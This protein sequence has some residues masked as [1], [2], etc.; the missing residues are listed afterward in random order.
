VRQIKYWKIHIFAR[1]PE[2]K[3][4]AAFALDEVA[5]IT[6]LMFFFIYLFAVGMALPSIPVHSQTIG[7]KQQYGNGIVDSAGQFS[8]QIGTIGAQTN[9]N[10][11][12]QLFQQALQHKAQGLA[13]L[14][15]GLLSQALTEAQQGIKA[16]DQARHFAQTSL[17]ALKSGETGGNV[18]LSGKYG[19]TQA[20][21]QNLANT[22]SPYLPEVQ[23][24]MNSFGIQVNHDK[25]VITTPFGEFPMDAGPTEMARTIAKIA[26]AFGLSGD[27]ATA[28]VQ[29]GLANANAIAQKA[30][31]DAKA[32]ANGTRGVASADSA[33]A[34]A[35]G[36]ID[37]SKD[38]KAAS[39]KAAAAATK[40][41]PANGGITAE[42]DMQ[43]RAAALANSRAE[44]LK[45]LGASADAIGGKDLSLYAIVHD[46]YQEMRHQ[47]SFNEYGDRDMAS[48]VPM[49]K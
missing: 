47:G 10:T 46:R 14:N 43:M 21:M 45:K 39:N 34:G 40:P 18:D 13:T 16:D 38:P 25:A 41:A 36:K 35:D 31:A 42:Q 5:M 48:V 23:S 24:S 28:G 6:K 4:G 37:P 11:A 12:D 49:T 22:S 20:D 3:F 30:L 17:E 32:A 26:P 44:L 9:R 29:A 7:V 1:C 19:T 2:I 8:Q 33:A 27:A 15:V